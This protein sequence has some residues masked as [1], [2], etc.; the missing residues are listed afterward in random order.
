MGVEVE[1][2]PFRALFDANPHP[3][4]VHDAETLALL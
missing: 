2:D 1:D 4:W 3:M